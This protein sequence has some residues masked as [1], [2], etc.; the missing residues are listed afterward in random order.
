MMTSFTVNLL[1][2][3]EAALDESTP[4]IFDTD[5]D[6]AL[7]TYLVLSANHPVRRESLSGLFWPEKSEGI[8]RHNLSQAIYSLHKQFQGK[9]AS[10][11]FEVTPQ[12]LIFRV[13]DPSGFDFYR[14]DQMRQG[15]KHHWTN[16][17]FTCNDCLSS[18]ELACTNYQGDFC[19]GLSLKE[20]N[21]FEEWICLQR[22]IYRLKFSKILDILVQGLCIGGDLEDALIYAYKKVFQDPYDESSQLQVIKVLVKLGRRNKARQHFESYSQMIFSELSTSPSIE[23]INRYE[24]LQSTT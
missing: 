7:F 15:C 14:F 18:L 6:R 19:A 3:F 5:K 8:A 11:P 2:G 20:C 10:N 24:K 12:S 23:M 21:N 17:V 22:E 1:G 9:F 13:R 16:P 4:L